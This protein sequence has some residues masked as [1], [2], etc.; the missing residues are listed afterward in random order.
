MQRRSS[1]GDAP[2]DATT[3][4]E[5]DTDSPPVDRAL[6]AASGDIGRVSSE[7]VHRAM[8]VPGDVRI[9]AFETDDPLNPFNWPVRKKMRITVLALCYA[10]MTG[11]NLG[12]YSAST[13][14]LRAAMSDSPSDISLQLGNAMW[15][16]AV[17]LS[18]L[19]L[20]PFSEYVCPVTS[21]QASPSQQ[22]THTF[23][24]EFTAA[25]GST[26]SASRYTAYPPYARSILAISPH[27]S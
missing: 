13:D 1:T 25:S 9:C 4:A 2:S 24:S 6:H 18:P 3:V 8:D 10:V 11:Y 19:I 22:L 7:K 14:D 27:C 26:Q 20:A 23:V 12:M 5:T 16:W 15:V 21:P 17:A